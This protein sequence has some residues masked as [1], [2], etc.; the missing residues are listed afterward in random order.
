MTNAKEV[1]RILRCASTTHG[2]SPDESSNCSLIVELMKLRKKLADMGA[3][4]IWI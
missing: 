1:R 4:W 2:V 3:V